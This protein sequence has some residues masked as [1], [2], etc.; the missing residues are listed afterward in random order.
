MAAVLYMYGTAPHNAFNG[1]IN[2][3][4]ASNIKMGL[5]TAYTKTAVEDQDTWTAV[6]ADGTEHGTG[7]TVTCRVTAAGPVVI[8]RRQTLHEI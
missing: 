4:G 8:T 6:K 3:D 2:W 5:L 1:D 7:I